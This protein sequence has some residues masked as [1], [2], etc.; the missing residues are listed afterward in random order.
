MT[1]GRNEQGAAKGQAQTSKE[2]ARKRIAALV[3]KFQQ[4][5]SEYLEKNYNETQARTEFITPLLEAFGWDVHNHRSLPR[6]YREVIEEATVEVGEEKLSKRPDYELRIARQKKLFVEAKKPS[7]RIDRDRSP[8]FQTRRYGYSASL[9]ISLVTNFRHLA[10]YDCVPAPDQSDEAHVAR[11]HLFSFDQFEE[12]FEELWSLISRE[13]VFSGEFDRRFSVDT[14]RRGAQQFDDFF[15]TQVRNWREKLAVDIHANTPGLDSEELT[16]VVQ[17]FISRI[18]FLRICEDRDLEKYESLKTLDGDSTF[19]EL[20]K[21]LRRADKFYNSGLFRVI[22]EDPLS[23]RISDSVLQQII[24]ELYYPLSPYTFAVIETEVLGEIYEQFLSEVIVVKDGAV[25]IDTKPEIRESGGV[26]STPRFIADF[27]VERTLTPLLAG[28]SPKE[29]ENFTV[30][31]TCCGS[32]IFLLSAFDFILGYYL[33]WYTTN[34]PEA[35]EG[36]TIYQV[37]QDLWRLTFDEKRRILM[38]H[39]RGVDIDENA[40]EVAQLSLLLKLIEDENESTL[41]EFVSRQK[42]AALPTLDTQ[43][44]AGNSLVSIPE[45]EEALGQFPQSLQRSVNPFSWDDEFPHEMENGG[46][47]AIIGNPP[48]IRIQN[49]V[50]Y[51][52]E[53]VEFYHSENSPYLTAHQ[54]NFDKYSLFIERSLNLAKGTGRIG[55][56]VPNKFMTIR[57]G[58][59]LRTTLSRRPILEEIINFGVKQVFGR[60]TSNYTCILTINCEGSKQ[61]SVEHPG[62]IEE[63]RYGRRG[64]ISTL[65]TS[66][67]G[68]E[69][70][71]FGKET[72]RSLFKRI[73]DSTTG[74]LSAL[75]NIEVG[76]QTSADK[77]F[78]LHALHDQANSITIEW[79]DQRWEIEKGILRPCLHDAKLE[80]FAF[81]EPNAWM[82]F[83][84]ELVNTRNGGRRARLLQPEEIASRYPNCWNYLNARRPLLEGRNITGGTA[85]E[86]QWYQYGRSQSLTKFD[87]PKILLPV[88]STE[89]KYSYDES[90][91]IITGGGNG[92]YYMIR[93]RDDSPVSTQFLLAVLNH[94]LCE[95]MI[96]TSTSVFRGGYYSH[97]K[98]FIQNLPIPIPNNEDDLKAVEAQV[99]KVISACNS[100]KTARTPRERTRQLRAVRDSQS[101]LEVQVSALFGL[102]AQ[103]IATVES[104]PIPS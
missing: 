29:I 7:V 70:W 39:L 18:V 81:P 34:D 51:S 85:A 55:M 36:E 4:N 53:E 20:K 97:G 84:Y 65:P 96:R 92:P 73:K 100:L 9:P 78:L 91:T 86:R 57:S 43:I 75:A 72:V 56:I 74:R 30:V 26:V 22:D 76:I 45:W 14:T 99:K 24:A 98:Q 54:D 103:D 61:L 38:A 68:D 17:L 94:P 19:D 50:N 47:D 77:V 62:P 89:A 3:H 10:I 6:I 52:P 60:A 35:Y 64:E 8:A 25:Q 69:P 44:C 46:F 93:A 90:D 32:G 87:Q 59:A 71:S 48:Y 49:M 82:I 63:W 33:D 37:R 41:K 12:C 79:E 31:D 11:T 66:E 23:V 28:K 102:S 13:S 88:L 5:K 1:K 42:V 27:I 2:E 80:A 95:A 40:V 104:V 58:R 67:L 83:P 101:K 15:L 21:V 16:Y